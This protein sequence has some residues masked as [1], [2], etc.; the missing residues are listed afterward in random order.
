MEPD[1]TIFTMQK[2]VW[3]F[4]IIAKACEAASMK[5]RLRIDFRILFILHE[6]LKLGGSLD[7]SMKLQIVL[8][9]LIIPE[10]VQVIDLLVF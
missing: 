6:F 2:G 10:E 9:N 5:D 3:L 7:S 1:P 8:F 4:V